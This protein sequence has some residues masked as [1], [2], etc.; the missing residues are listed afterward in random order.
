MRDAG[1]VGGEAC[2]VCAELGRPDVV[3]TERVTFPLRLFGRGSA[4]A[5]GPVVTGTGGLPYLGTGMVAR[6]GRASTAVFCV[7]HA[8]RARELAER[9]L[10]LRTAVEEMVAAETEA[11]G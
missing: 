3:G 11:G 8:P 4:T 9:R 1:E 7:D 2:R 5:V 10:G 6:R